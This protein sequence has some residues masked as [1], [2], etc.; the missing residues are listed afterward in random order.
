[1]G[2]GAVVAVAEGVAVATAVAV[3]VAVAARAEICEGPNDVKARATET[4]RA[5]VTAGYA[6]T[7]RT[8]TW[9]ALS[10]FRLFTSSAP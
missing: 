1:M 7:A 4:T 10:F 3:A 2:M 9:R 8:R 6:T 5:T